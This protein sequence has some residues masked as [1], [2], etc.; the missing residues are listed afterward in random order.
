TPLHVFVDA[1]R[2]KQ[3]ISNLMANAMNHTPKGGKIEI[4]VQARRSENPDY[5]GYALIHVRD[6]GVGVPSDLLAQVF[7][8]FE[9][10]AQ[11]S[12][13]VTGTALGLSLAK[14]IAELH[15]GEITA[16]SEMGKGSTF[17]VKLLLMED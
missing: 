5:P 15:G 14:E 12:T 10:A 8:P 7:Q 16:T 13:V 17:S 4:E 6:N 9:A 2:T 1:N 3:L 11:G